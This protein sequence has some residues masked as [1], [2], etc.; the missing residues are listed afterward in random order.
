MDRYSASVDER[1]TIGCF[2]DFQDM[3]EVPRNT[4]KP[5]IKRRVSGQEA[6]SESAKALSYTLEFDEKKSPWPRV[7]LM[8]YKM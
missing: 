4:Q 3:R 6:Q 7:R 8:Y 1:E 5:K 2:L